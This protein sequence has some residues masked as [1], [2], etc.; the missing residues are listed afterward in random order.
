MQEIIEEA[1]E[2]LRENKDKVSENILLNRAEDHF[3]ELD[4]YEL[5]EILENIINENL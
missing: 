2:Y 4:Y 3:P 1:I 5:S